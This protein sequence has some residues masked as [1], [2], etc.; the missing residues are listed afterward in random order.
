MILIGLV[1]SLHRGGI[2]RAGVRF[3]ASSQPGR[4]CRLYHTKRKISYKNEITY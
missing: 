4:H 1:F 3:S 2:L